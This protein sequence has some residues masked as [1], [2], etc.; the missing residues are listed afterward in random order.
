MATTKTST[1]RMPG[2]PTMIEGYKNELRPTNQFMVIGV[3]RGDAKHEQRDGIYKASFT[4][5]NGDDDFPFVAYG[6]AALNA[7]S[8]C[9]WGSLLQVVGRIKPTKKGIYLI[10]VDVILIAK[11]PDE[12]KETMMDWIKAY[13]P[14]AIMKSDGGEKNG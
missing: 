9:S 2:R 5:S 11:K 13:N 7:Y 6:Q 14:E 1:R 12:G 4:I 10:A 3:C 8:A